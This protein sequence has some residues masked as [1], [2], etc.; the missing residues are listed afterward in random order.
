MS[1][2]LPMTFRSPP[3]SCFSSATAF[4]TSPVIWVEFGQRSGSVEVEATYFEALFKASANGLSG[5]EFQ[6]PRMSS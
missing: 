3:A 6:C 5:T 1:T 2:P 4:G